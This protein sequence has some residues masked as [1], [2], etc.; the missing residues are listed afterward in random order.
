MGTYLLQD[1]FRPRLTDIR[2][3]VRAKNHAIDM[4]DLRIA[5]GEIVAD[6]QPLFGIGYA[7]RM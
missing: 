6:A 4:I 5:P 1:L 2:D 7:L 3:T